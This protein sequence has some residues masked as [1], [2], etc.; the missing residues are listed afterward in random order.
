MSFAPV[1]ALARRR[2]GPFKARARS[3]PD[4]SGAG[5]PGQPQPRRPQLRRP[6]ERGGGGRT[7]HRGAAGAH[8]VL[9]VG[10]GVP[11]GMGVM[12]TGGGVWGC[13]GAGEGRWGIGVPRVLGSRRGG[14]PG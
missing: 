11:R 13:Q 1:S 14:C 7:T 8:G 10:T 12:G 9:G 6:G 2:T 4:V 3:R 5:T